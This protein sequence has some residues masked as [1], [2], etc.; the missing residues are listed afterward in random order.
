MVGNTKTTILGY[1]DLIVELTE[2]LD[3]TSFPLKNVVYCPRFYINLISAERAANA[4][5][6]LNGRDCTLEEK[7][8]T[9]ICRLNAKLGIYL[10]KWDKTT[11]TGRS[12][13]YVS[14]PTPISHLA[15][16]SALYDLVSHDDVSPLTD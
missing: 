6:Y 15:F 14:L 10:I 11:T 4:R 13:N 8:G 5:I 9:P 16:T 2:S 12:T 3:G 1:G 7:D